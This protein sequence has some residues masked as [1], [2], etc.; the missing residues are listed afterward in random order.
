MYNIILKYYTPPRVS[1]QPII[2]KLFVTSH[3]FTEIKKGI[4]KILFKVYNN[5]ANIS[6][7]DV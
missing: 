2:I 4:D 5:I 6:K 7:K 1:F 3:F